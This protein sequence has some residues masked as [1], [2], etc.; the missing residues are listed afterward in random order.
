MGMNWEMEGKGT[1]R[2][3][4]QVRRGSAR[5]NG[6]G[7]FR[8]FLAGCFLWT[9]A[10]GAN[11]AGAEP[12]VAS[13]ELLTTNS[14]FVRHLQDP[15]W[16]REMKWGESRFWV[17][18]REP[19]ARDVQGWVTITNRTGVQPSGMFFEQLTPVPE[20]FLA[21]SSP[22]Q[23][24]VSGLS[25]HY[26]WAANVD[27][28]SIALSS[29][30][31]EEGAAEG[32]PSQIALDTKRERI[33]R[34]RHLGFPVLRTNSFQLPGNNKFKA[35]TAEGQLVEGEVLK[36]SNDLPLILKY[37]L[38]GDTGACVSVT[39]SYAP[40]ESLPNYMERRQFKNGRPDPYP[41]TNWI[42]K[43]DYGID[44][45]ITGGYAFAMFFPD[46]KLFNR[47]IIE[48]N[49]QRF[50]I[51]QNQQMA[52]IDETLPTPFPS[53]KNRSWVAVLIISLSAG[54]LFMWRFVSGSREKTH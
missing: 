30:R 35:V 29:R 23:R 52:L 45:S 44:G 15:P 9:G 37:W 42:E 19:V 24:V 13:G 46:P 32:S 6:K 11:A 22:T 14:P 33:E 48:S 47:F 5:M 34:I 25:D 36:L 28:H 16:I 51:R 21:R 41:A 31:P 10:A 26:Y 49:G 4:D 3:G 38:N 43:V 50:L 17:A 1:V 8:G 7:L 27:G 53:H 2:R 20:P 12:A 54:G 40:D 18:H 39:Y